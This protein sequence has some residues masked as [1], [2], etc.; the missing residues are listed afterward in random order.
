MSDLE[1]VNLSAEYA[2][3]L[4][5][6]ELSVFS[7]IDP[8]DLYN[9]A[10]LELLAQTFPEGNF[11]VLDG[12]RPIGMGLGILVEF[13]FEHTEHSLA[14]VCGEDGVSNHDIDNPWYYGTDISVYPEY[15]GRGIGRRLYELRKD[16]VRR[17]NKQ[18]IVAGGVI[19]GYA[20]HVHDMSAEEYIAKVAAGEL[21]DP[22]LSF[23]LNNGFVAHGALPDYLED[24]TVGNN[25]VLIVWRNPDYR[26]RA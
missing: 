6:L 19:P 23:Q 18:G 7:T 17:L 16:C 10:E 24:P 13:D 3:A 5:E 9:A 11:V 21:H 1:Y 4:E 15:R 12:G 26:D 22:T 20:D 25:S 8:V 2:E 14:D